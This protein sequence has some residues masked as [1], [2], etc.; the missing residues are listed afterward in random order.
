MCPHGSKLITPAP[1]TALRNELTDVPRS[2]RHDWCTG[3]RIGY[4]PSDIVT[5]A[6]DTTFENTDGG[7][8]NSLARVMILHP[9]ACGLAFIAFLT[10][11]GG[12]TIMSS[13][14]GSLVA[15][16]TWILE[17]VSLVVDFTAF[18]IIRH[19]VNDQTSGPLPKA[20]FGN[21][22]WCLVASFIFLNGGMFIIG[23]SFLG[24]FKEKR[25]DSKRATEAQAASNGAAT[26]K[27]KKKRFGIF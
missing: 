26:E 12:R 18:G 20:Q 10:T 3:R 24:A 17:L 1:V 23:M 2:S 13:V 8:A 27:K 22:M 5:R 19:E 25:A 9:I 21:A 14:S 4:N 7:T 6:T 11:L 16:L 15:G